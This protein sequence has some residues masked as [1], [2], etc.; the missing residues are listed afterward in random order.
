M[1][2]RILHA[3]A[4]GFPDSATGARGSLPLEHARA[5]RGPGCA[6][7]RRLADRAGR[8][9]HRPPAMGAVRSGQPGRIRPR[10]EATDQQRAGECSE[11]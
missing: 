2:I 5:L 1:T 11:V 4:N 8:V 3:S 6:G 10:G 7:A 9:P